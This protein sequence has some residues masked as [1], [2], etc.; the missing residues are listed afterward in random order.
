[1]FPALG[2]WLAGV[3]SRAS[4]RLVAALAEA[5]AMPDLEASGRAWGCFIVGGVGFDLVGSFGRAKFPPVIGVA[6]AVMNGAL[7]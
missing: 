5:V 2:S 4:A 7:A 1:M 6:A 3:R